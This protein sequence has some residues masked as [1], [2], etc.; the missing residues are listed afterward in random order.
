MTTGYI[1][2][3]W[4]L[5]VHILI[6][7]IINIQN[8]HFNALLLLA[9]LAM[10]CTLYKWLCRVP[11]RSATHCWARSTTDSIA[12][13]SCTTSTTSCPAGQPP[14]PVAQ[15]AVSHA[16]QLPHVARPVA[17][18]RAPQPSWFA[19]RRLPLQYHRLPLAVSHVSLDYINKY[20]D[21][22][23]IFVK[24][25]CSIESMCQAI[26]KWSAQVINLI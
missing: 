1:S 16:H 13:T 20:L 3:L 17:I 11:V 2:G 8:Y 14:Q 5:A 15:L 9:A 12:A 21:S 4:I 22:S 10:C 6:I 23:S 24:I 18:S 26:E 7:S 19:T 25:Q